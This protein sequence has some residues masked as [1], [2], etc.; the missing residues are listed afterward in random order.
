[1]LLAMTLNARPLGLR[2]G[3]A[4]AC[5]AAVS[6]GSVGVSTSAPGAPTNALGVA[7]NA[8]VV[9]SWSAPLSNGGSAIS[10]YTVMASPGEQSCSWSSGPLSCTVTGLTNGTAYTFAVTAAND[11]RTGPPSS[12]SAPVTPRAQGA[13]LTPT[14]PVSAASIP[15]DGPNPAGLVP[16]QVGDRYDLRP[17]WDANHTGQGVR[18]ALIEVGTSIDAT[19]LTRYQECIHTGPVPFFAHQVGLGPLPPPSGRPPS[20]T[21]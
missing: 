12:P 5:L 16:S 11:Q 17:L 14:A 3:V 21:A 10:S 13:A 20:V 6:L 1:M 19:V 9:V 4:T 18:V 7:G 15:C 2:A 8:E